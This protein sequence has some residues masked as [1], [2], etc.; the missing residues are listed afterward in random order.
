MRINLSYT[1]L[2]VALVSFVSQVFAGERDFPGVECLDIKVN[3]RLKVTCHEAPSVIV[4]WDDGSEAPSFREKKGALKIR[5]QQLKEETQKASVSVKG[6]GISI[7]G[8]SNVHVGN[9]YTIDFDGK[10]AIKSRGKSSSS[11]RAQDFSQNLVEVFL[12]ERGLTEGMEMNLLCEAYAC[13]INERIMKNI[14]KT[15]YTSFSGA[16]QSVGEGAE[17]WTRFSGTGSLKF[18]WSSLEPLQPLA[19]LS[20]AVGGV[21]IREVE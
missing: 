8:A 1:V 20:S 14:Q 2:S 6:G 18:S 12:P 7:T 3:A 15:A 4:K 19:S 17:V 21:T 5:D 16:Q 9:T 11:V 10:K 13:D